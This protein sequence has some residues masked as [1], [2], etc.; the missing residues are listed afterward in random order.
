MNVEWRDLQG[1]DKA[2]AL[3]I[4]GEVLRLEQLL[5][6]RPSSGECKLRKG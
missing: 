5:R 1:I 3:L 6:L 4:R 2:L